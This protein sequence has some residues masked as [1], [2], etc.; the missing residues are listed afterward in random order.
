MYRDAG[1]TSGLVRQL[2]EAPVYTAILFNTV[3]APLGDVRIRQA[4]VLGMDRASIV[5][6]DTY[7]TG[8]L[9]AADLSPFYWAFDPS[10]APV[11]YDLSRAK[12]L[13]DAAGWRPGPTACA[14]ATASG[15]RC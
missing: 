8:K 12:A 1:T 3:R 2:A 7:G 11:P 4:L 6:D 10:L 9:A 14:F 13:L 5:R 15:F